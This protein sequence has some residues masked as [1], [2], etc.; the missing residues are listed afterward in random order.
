MRSLRGRLAI[1]W[2]ICLLAASAVGFLLIQLYRTSAEA[3]LSRAQAITAQACGAIQE[4]Y[5]F[6]VAGWA[7]GPELPEDAGFRRDLTAIVTLALGGH[8]GVEGGIWHEE[9]GSLAYAFPT[10]EGSSAKLDLPAAE[11]ATIQALNERVRQEGRAE[12]LQVR[13]STQ[14]RV[15]QGCP[16]DGPLPGMTA[17]TMTQ[18]QTSAAYDRVRLGTAVLLLLVLAMAGWLAWVAGTFS[19]HIGAIERTLLVR[20]AERLPALQRTGERELDRIVDALNDAAGR[21]DAAQ[22][23]ADEMSRQLQAN[24]RLAALGRVAAGLAHEIRNPIAAMRLKAENAL[25]GDDARR[26][27]ALS[28]ILGQIERLDRLIADLLTMTQRHQPVSAEVDVAA[29]LADVAADY[30]EQASA[31]DVR[32]SVVAPSIR[33]RLDAA[34]VRRALDDLVRNAVRHSFAEGCVRLRGVA[35]EG[36]I[37]ITVEDDGPGVPPELRAQIFEPF[38]TGSASGTGLGLAIAREIVTAL[39]GTLHLLDTAT[40]AIFAIDL[41][42][43]PS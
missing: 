41:P 31:A 16:L 39:G 20:D 7:S 14:S 24:E 43:R 23:H 19:R 28:V 22:R 3:S 2:V 30:A 25:A 29:V 8:A 12:E 9:A 42:C 21:I 32:L 26:A 11:A 5:A 18:V 15:L 6:Y 35:M 36:S 38:V 40:G 1:L 27:K 10:Y 34:L 37:R 33:C 4:R 13:G 17:W